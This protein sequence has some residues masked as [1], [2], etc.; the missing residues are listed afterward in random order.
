M[1]IQGIKEKADVNLVIA[2]E[3]LIDMDPYGLVVANADEPLE[4]TCSA[5]HARYGITLN[6]INHNLWLKVF[7][8]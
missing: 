6:F 8:A 1:D 7:K 2:N 4:I 5:R 3:G